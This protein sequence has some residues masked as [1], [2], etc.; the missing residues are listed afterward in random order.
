MKFKEIKHNINLRTLS[1]VTSEIIKKLLIKHIVP[2]AKELGLINSINNNQWFN[3]FNENGIKHVIQFQKT[4]GNQAILAYGNCFEFLPT[5][6]GSNK[7]VNHRTDKST[8]LH[9]FEYANTATKKYFFRTK[10]LESISLNNEKEFEKTLS[11]CILGHKEIIRNWFKNNTSLNQ[12]IASCIRQSN[13]N[14]GYA[15]HYPTYDYVLS[16]LYSKN[17]DQL[18]ASEK[19][20]NFKTNN[21]ELYNS[22]ILKNIEQKINIC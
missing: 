16:F 2:V 12:N 7:I 9:L 22:E 13:Q 19:W 5:I 20:C 15:Q 17:S 21:Q 3:H 8:K 6:S 1:P 11:N 18:K 10:Q 14:D 4:K